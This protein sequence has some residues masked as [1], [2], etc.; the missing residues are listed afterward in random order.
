MKTT[1]V[2]LPTSLFDCKNKQCPCC[3][4]I[5]GC[6]YEGDEDGL[7]KNVVECDDDFVLLR[8]ETDYLVKDYEALKNK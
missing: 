6:K 2:S 1:L 3:I 7:N 4:S 5:P 8:M